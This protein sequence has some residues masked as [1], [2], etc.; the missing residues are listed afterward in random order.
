MKKNVVRI[1]TAVLMLSVV[2]SSSVFAA[3]KQKS[4]WESFV[5]LFTGNA[6]TVADTQVDGV[7]YRTHIQNDGWKQGWVSDG[8]MSGSEGRGLRLEGIEIEIDGDDLP[9]GLGVTYRTQIENDGWLD[10]ETDGDTSGSVGK[11]LR[12]EAI[13]I[14]LTGDDA[15]DYS[16]GYR[17]HIQNYGWEEDWVYN[18][19]TSGT[20][21]EGLRL[22]GIQIEIFRNIPDLTEYEAALAAVTQ[23]DY[24]AA[25]WT[26]YQA[27]VNANV[28]DEDNLVSEVEEATA[29]ITAAQANLVKVLK[30]ESVS[31]IN[32]NQ[33]LVTY[34]G[35]V[36]KTTAETLANYTFEGK[37]NN[38]AGVVTTITAV[39][40]SNTTTFAETPKATLQADGK[41]VLITLDTNTTNG[42]LQL[43]EPQVTQ[44][45]KVANVK[46]A[47]GTA[48]T[49]VTNS[50][51][52]VDTTIPT[53]TSV[54]AEG[55]RVIVVAFSEFV[56]PATATV[57][58]NYQIDG[59]SLTA[60]GAGTGA[61]DAA[62][63]VVRF[64]LS[65]ALADKTYV[66]K[67]SVNNAITDAIGLKVVEAT[68]DLKIVADT[69]A[70]KVS[71][72]EV[73]K[74][75]SGGNYILIKFTKPLA[76]TNDVITG[77]PVL[78]DNVNQNA[79]T[80]VVNGNLK[81][82]A[83]AV[84][85]DGAHAI[86]I[87]N[88]TTN[89]LLDAFGVKVETGSI[90]Y[91]IA[92]DTVKPAVSS[93]TVLDGNAQVDVKFTKTVDL[94]TAQNRLN[95]TITNSSSAQQ[96]IASAVLKTGTTDTI[97]LTLNT[98]LK[99]GTFTV[100]IQ[101]VKDTAS[102]PN[103]MNAYTGTL[104]VVDTVKPTVSS[105][106]Y[107]NAT[108]TVYVTYSKDMN[109]TSIT[110]AANYL[111]DNKALPS[112]TTITAL[113]NT[114]AKLKFASDTVLAGKK[115]AVSTGA[116]DVSGNPLSGFGYETTLAT[117]FVTGTLDVAPADSTVANYTQ[118]TGQKTV[119]VKLNNALEILTASEFS[120]SIDNGTNYTPFTQQQA[121]FT[122]TD[123]KSTITFT[124][125][126]TDAQI[127]NKTTL[128][129]VK[130][131]ANNSGSTTKATDGSTINT[132]G[133]LV[134]G[135]TP[136]DK[137][138]PA[139]FITSG[140]GVTPVTYNVLVSDG[141]ANGKVDTM[142]IQFSEALK[143]GS[144]AIDDFAVTGLTVNNAT[145]TTTTVGN[146]TVTLALNE[147]TVVDTL[148]TFAVTLKGD[149]EDSVGNVLKA[150]TSKAYTAAASAGAVALASINGNTGTAAQYATLGVTG[151]NASN[152]TA[153]NAAVAAAKPVGGYT[154]AAAIQAAANTGIATYNGT[155]ASITVKTAPT[156]VAY[157]SGG[158]LNLAG[159]VVTLTKNDASTE[160]VAF[161]NFAAKGIT[162]AKANGAAL[163]VADTAVA[164]THTASG[165]SVNQAITVAPISLSAVTI[166]TTASAINGVISVN[167]LTPSAAT[168]T[169]QWQ[170][171]AGAGAFANIAGATSATYTIPAGTLSADRFQLVITGSGEYTGTVTSTNAITIP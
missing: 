112:D 1:L 125:P 92:A 48:I 154:T 111:L 110:T 13:E 126:L 163:V 171:A 167:V 84:V 113:S 70:A 169:Y 119:T 11:G 153:V 46:D 52:Y 56:K 88:D 160:D 43:L 67:Y 68:A 152:L 165:Q 9:D 130:I 166:Q 143:T 54:S 53:V 3:E 120:Y 20:V 115:F 69:T 42:T 72:V 33:I 105:V 122:T 99:A 155:V 168:V 19:D 17:T 34:N 76:A 81:V 90:T 57:A 86:N 151:V 94:T 103:T 32:A 25:S 31:A 2:F 129:N 95:Y 157:T 71:S 75:T 40:L 80:T 30:V 131:Q 149:V 28:V 104:T 65:S 114:V 118:A 132:T 83:G 106:T 15:G 135:I 100:G 51:T 89:Y 142:T 156:T 93:V 63:N 21:G 36:D 64:T 73:V 97:T 117:P 134:A 79:S 162:T 23:A 6:V 78:I 127:L 91:T 159:L 150:D 124:L 140:A 133:S 146:D 22:E 59:V 47:A 35:A 98:A 39:A 10:W 123:G 102:T 77:I 107:D 138:A 16:I 145:V 41:S 14:E 66:F 27:V 44:K 26:A 121:S 147:G 148:D 82:T 60:Y 116:T 161:A 96:T 141:N 144:V 139:V 37:T 24:T 5:G 45:L 50:F 170:K 109:T 58:S 101:G 62:T 87:K 29:A 74:P 136:A 61:Y 49:A 85:S 108:K 18:G 158:T 38:G 12:L 7:T 137:V 128:S 55:N 164:I 8:E 4:A